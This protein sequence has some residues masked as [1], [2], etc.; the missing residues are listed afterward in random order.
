[1]K[2]PEEIGRETAEKTTAEIK[3]SLPLF[4]ADAVLEACFHTLLRLLIAKGILDAQE[5]L[6]EFSKLSGELQ[7]RRDSPVGVLTLERLCSMLSAL[8]GAKRPMA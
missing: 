1:M 2:T 6:D 8:P 4:Q 5:V 3:R 7:F